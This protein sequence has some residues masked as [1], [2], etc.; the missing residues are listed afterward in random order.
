MSHDRADAVELASDEM[1]LAPDGFPERCPT[2]RSRRSTSITIRSR[3]TE[4]V[5]PASPPFSA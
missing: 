5:Y 2:A 3:E 4:I 1:G